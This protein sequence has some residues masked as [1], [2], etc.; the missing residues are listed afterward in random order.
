MYN[1]VNFNDMT[2]ISD[3]GMADVSLPLIGIT[4]GDMNGVGYEVILKAFEDPMMFELCTPVLYGSS[5][6]LNQYR[7]LL[8]VSQPQYNVIGSAA[9]A[10]AGVLNVVNVTDD[11]AK[12]EPGVNSPAAGVAAVAALECAVADLKSGEIDALVTAPINKSNVQGENFDFAGHT[13]YLESALA[14][15]GE[16]AMMILCTD[17]IRI[18]LV[19]THLPLRE[20]SEAITVDGVRDGVLRLAESLTRDFGVH[21]PRVAV[22]SLNP[23]SGDSGLLGSEESEVI[24][25]AIEQAQAKGVCV[26]GPYA[27]DGFFG[28]GAYRHFDG[29]LAMYHDQGLAPFKALCM[30]D[31]VNFTAGL[32]YVRTSPDHG[33][34]YDIAGKGEASAASMRS[35]IYRAI[36]VVRNRERHLE[37][38]RNPLRRHYHDKGK[39]NVVLDLTKEN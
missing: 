9:D 1:I 15:D 5:R 16:R 22:L 13:E 21:A 3:N 12:A 23:H 4:H 11:E 38:T 33:T 19:T 28:S 17:S 29:V 20:V 24:V 27:A 32:D 36:D 37:A 30:D 2:D 18:A 26:F 39:D 31:G 10:R 8:G 25:P 7:K 35:A 14:E 6:V 34:G